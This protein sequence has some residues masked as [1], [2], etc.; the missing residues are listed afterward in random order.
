[1]VKLLLSLNDLHKKG[2]M[3]RD[4]KLENIMILEKGND[5]IDPIIIDL[6]L[7]EK[8]TNET[9]LYVKCGTPGYVAP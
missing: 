9:F 2:Y 8:Y 6:G 7:A 1:M 5:K 3:H 4:L